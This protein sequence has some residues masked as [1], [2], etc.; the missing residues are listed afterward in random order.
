MPII[1]RPLDY[2]D[3]KG[4]IAIEFALIST[5][6]LVPLLLGASDFVVIISARAQLNTALQALYY[7]AWT[8][9]TS[10]ADSTQ[11]AQVIAAINAQS[12]YQITNPTVSV[13]Y[14]CATPGSTPSYTTYTSP[15]NCGQSE[16]QQT[17]TS[18]KISTNVSLPVTFLGIAS[19]M[20]YSANGTIQTQ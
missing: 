10:A 12:I 2:R 4:S 18:Y 5:F 16:V 11:L 8:N 9:P 17:L 20:Q 7:F 13:T 19:P 6:F 14:V 1:K 15:G 3:R